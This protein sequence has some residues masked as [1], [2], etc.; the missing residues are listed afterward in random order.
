M[1]V[2]FDAGDVVYF[3]EVHQRRATACLLE[4]V[5]VEYR[6]GRRPREN[7]CHANAVR[8]AAENLGLVPVHGWLIEAEDPC[9]IRLLAHTVVSDE[10]GRFIDVTPMSNPVR[11]FLAHHGSSADFF[12]RLPHCSQ[13]AWPVL[14]LTLTMSASAAGGLGGPSQL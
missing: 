8:W 12:R 6:D 7:D 13:V 1:T 4:R 2:T 3:D 14:D 11:R 9:Q 5:E 10:A